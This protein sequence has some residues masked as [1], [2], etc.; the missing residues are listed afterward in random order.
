MDL[1]SPQKYISVEATSFL[2]TILRLKE[3]PTIQIKDRNRI[4]EIGRNMTE[5]DNPVLV[6]DA[7]PK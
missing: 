6:I 4:I 7:K 1:I 2:S 5:S 3:D